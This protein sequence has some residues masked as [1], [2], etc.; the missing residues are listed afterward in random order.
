M[1]ASLVAFPTH[2]DLQSL[3]P[4]ATQAQPVAGEFI[5]KA[6]HGL[7]A[8]PTTLWDVGADKGA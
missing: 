8:Q 5:R 6:I 7:A 4:R 1:V 2:V 3:Q